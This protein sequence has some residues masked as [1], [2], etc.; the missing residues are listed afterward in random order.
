MAGLYFPN[1]YGGLTYRDVN[2]NKEY[3]QA[4]RDVAK[5]IRNGKEVPN[6]TM[7]AVLQWNG[8]YDPRQ[9]LFKY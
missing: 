2:S 5:A 1:R 7:Q 3:E 4:S 8:Y 6:Q 9:L